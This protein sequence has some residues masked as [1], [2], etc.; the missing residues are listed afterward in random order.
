MKRISK[1]ITATT[2][3]L[4]V[5]AT[6]SVALAVDSPYGAA[7]ASLDKDY[8]IE[9]ML[10]YAIQDEYLA[11]AEYN[12]IMNEY[13]VQRPFSNIVKAEATHIQ[14][15]LPLFET[16]NINVPQDDAASIVKLPVSL[17]ETY[18]AGV[19]AEIANIAM[20]E[21]FQ[22]EDLP[23]D[24]KLVFEKLKAASESHLTAFERSLSRSTNYDSNSNYNYGRGQNNPSSNGLG[25]NRRDSINGNS[26]KNTTK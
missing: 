9:E 19:N 16:Y 3:A 1:I 17:L 18:E 10:T 23:M 4:T 14:L 15:L 2:L 11:Q 22:L 25:G 24:V 20:Y 6:T 8:T 5:L 26:N 12:A 7:G 21:S 13:G